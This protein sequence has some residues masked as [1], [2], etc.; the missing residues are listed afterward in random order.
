MGETL[1]PRL[2]PLSRLSAMEL[3]FLPLRAASMNENMPLPL[4]RVFLPVWWIAKKTTTEKHTHSHM[5]DRAPRVKNRTPFSTPFLSCNQLQRLWW[6]WRFH[7]SS[8]PSGGPNLP[9]TRQEANERKRAK[10]SCVRLVVLRFGVKHSNS[11]NLSY[12]AVRFVCWLG[13]GERDLTFHD[14][15]VNFRASE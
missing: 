10:E 4:R 11:I 14:R 12:T 7:S 9:T 15:R 2:R 5:N 13:S 3:F 6:W 1:L 8:I